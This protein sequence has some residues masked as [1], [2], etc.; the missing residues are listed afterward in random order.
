[1][2]KNTKEK[3]KQIEKP[4]LILVEG[5]TDEKFFNSLLKHLQ[6]DH[7]LY[8]IWPSG[9][10][11]ELLKT[12]KILEKVPGF[13]RLKLL[14]IFLDADENSN[15]TFKRVRDAL[16][17]AELPVP[18]RQFELVESKISVIAGTI[19]PEEDTGTFKKAKFRIALALENL[20]GIDSA[21]QRDLFDFNSSTLSPVREALKNINRFA[22]P[23]DNR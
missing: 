16:S 5:V 18:A 14:M 21:S 15:E 19:P 11:E 2:A 7:E 10:K 8:D 23:I 4:C 1:M 17:R 6:I 12:I 22:E 13:D 3:P 9:G 20:P